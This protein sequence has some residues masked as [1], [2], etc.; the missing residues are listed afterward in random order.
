[1][2]MMDISFGGQKVSINVFKASQYPDFDEG[3]HAVETLGEVIADTLELEQFYFSM[4][5]K[6][7][8]VSADLES[9]TFSM[10]DVNVLHDSPHL[11]TS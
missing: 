1:M 6:D 8:G 9:F 7:L 4:G 3:C 2:G 10:K 5:K 11:T